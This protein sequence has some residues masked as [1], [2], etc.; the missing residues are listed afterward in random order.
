MRIFEVLIDNKIQR[1]FAEKRNG[2]LWLHWGG[3]TRSFPL[4]KKTS[5][6]KGGVAQAGSGEIL[7]PMPG[8]ILKVNVKPGDKAA[9]KQVLVVMEAMKMEYSLSCDV[10]GVVKEVRCKEGDQVELGALLVAVT[11]EGDKK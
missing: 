6:K 2:H 9:M 1:V 8:K 4:Q 7:A 3:R 11:P 5:G 10:N